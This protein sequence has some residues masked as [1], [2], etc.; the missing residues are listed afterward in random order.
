MNSD[1]PLMAF[2]QIGRDPERLGPVLSCYLNPNSVD[3]RKCPTCGKLVT[4]RQGYEGASAV[5][6][7]TGPVVWTDHAGELQLVFSHRVLEDVESIGESGFLAHPLPITKVENPRLAALD[8]PDYFLIEVIGSIDIDR[9]HYDGGDGL[10]CDGCR[11][12]R[13][14]PGGKVTY[15]DKMILPVPESWDGSDFVKCRNIRHGGYYCTARIV[16]LARIKG[17]TGFEF[18]ALLPVLP[19]VDLEDPRWLEKIET[20][21]HEKYPKFFQA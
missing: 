10:L 18:T 16:E 15:G 13:P 6:E 7:G 20:A 5:S 12:W 14:R 1:S 17:W 9:T 21:A 19:A 4:F 2:F 11:V 8:R 3:R